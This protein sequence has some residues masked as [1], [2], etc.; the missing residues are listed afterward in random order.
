MA[1][2][3][4]TTDSREVGN[5]A[6]ENLE[7][8]ITFTVGGQL[9]GIPI[10]MVQEILRLD[11]IAAIPLAPPEVKGSIDLRGRIGTV[12]S[13]RVRLGLRER[14]VDDASIIDD[15]A[16]NI[17]TNKDAIDLIEAEISK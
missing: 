15:A 3:L 17:L 16:E 1:R 5:I 8:F 9:F 12:V 2:D 11:E 14:G 4:I 13:V 7:D 10:L 6:D